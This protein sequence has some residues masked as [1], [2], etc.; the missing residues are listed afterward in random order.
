M[1]VLAYSFPRNSKKWMKDLAIK[2]R[3]FLFTH[4]K[5]R[6]INNCCGLR[7]APKRKDH[8]SWRAK[9]VDVP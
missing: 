4:A 9:D 2:F 5:E 3:G 7:F 8:P 6:K 1:R